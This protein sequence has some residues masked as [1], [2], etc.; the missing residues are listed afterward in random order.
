MLV[1]FSLLGMSGLVGQFNLEIITK[2]D[3]VKQFFIFKSVPYFELRR[4]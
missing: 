1:K 4:N 2:E 3:L